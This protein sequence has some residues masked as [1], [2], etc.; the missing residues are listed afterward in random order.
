MPGSQRQ[1]PAYGANVS[2]DLDALQEQSVDLSSEENDF[3]SMKAL[4]NESKTAK[5][6]QEDRTTVNIV[7]ILIPFIMANKSVSEDVKKLKVSFE[8]TPRISEF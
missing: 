1:K 6:C 3:T 5:L 7:G 4:I 8:K 2:F